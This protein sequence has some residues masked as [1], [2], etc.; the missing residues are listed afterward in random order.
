LELTIRL[1]P[2]RLRQWHRRLVERAA[3]LG[4]MQVTVAW[5]TAREAAPAGLEALY[6]FER[7]VHGR[8]ASDLAVVARPDD[9]APFQ[10]C[11][12]RTPDLVIDLCADRRVAGEPTWHVTFDGRH[13]EAAA[14]GALARGRTPVVSVIDAE[15]GTE[16]ASGHPGTEDSRVLVRA[17]ADVMARTITILVAALEGNPVF[18]DRH[19][20][21]RPLRTADVVRA[22]GR[23]MAHAVA[24]RLYR[25]LY[26]TPHWRTGWRFVDGPDV[27]VLGTHP[28]GGW[29]SLAD[30]GLRCYADPFPVVKDDR[31]YVF[32]E[33]MNPQR[34]R[35]VI[36]VVEFDEAGPIGAPRPV[37]DTGLHV[38]YPFV[39]EHAGAMWMVPESSA[40]ANVCLWR[41]R[42]FPDVWD[43]EAVLLSGIIAS[44]ATLFQHDGRWWMLATV[45]EEG[46]S[47]SD[48][49]HIW[50]ADALVGPWR[51]HRHNPVLVDLASA[52]PAGRVV[53]RDGKLL[54]PVQDCR[55]GYGAALAIAE[56]VRLDEEC[57]E[58][59]VQAIL[60]PG[61]SWPGH[62]LHMLNQAGRLECIDGA[63]RSTR[64]HWRRIVAAR[65]TVRMSAP[66]S[67]GE[68]LDVGLAKENAPNIDSGALFPRNRTDPTSGAR[69][70]DSLDVPRTWLGGLPI[71]RLSR[72]ET[73]DLM[74]EAV[75]SRSSRQR[76]LILTSAN[77]EV[78]SRC[79]RD[80]ALAAM[81]AV[82]DLISADG[83]PLVLAS[84]LIGDAP[85]PERVATTD[86]FH[87]VARRA[88]RHGISFYLFGSTEAENANACS[89]ILASYP[90]LKIAGRSH[91]YLTGDALVERVA[92][93]NALAPD[94]VWVGLG[95][96]REQ[97]F[98]LSFAKS[99]SNVGILKTSG[100]L[101]NFLSGT[102]AR[103]PAWMQGIGLEWA[104]RAA[105]EPRLIWRYAVTNPH[106]LYLLAR[107]HRLRLNPPHGAPN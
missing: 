11:Q 58:Q 37:L 59:R 31:T 54:R 28:P 35:G 68:N 40:E 66:G 43:K 21:G 73:A 97:A 32:V 44:D 39:F 90:N 14:V 47:Y 1:D 56:I 64:L 2:T 83:Q 99:L 94:I 82:A 98:C 38:S 60:G 49:L 106:A 86:L 71:T 3:R 70:A 29:Q 26:Q 36:S 46:G 67:L 93:I 25:R 84:K 24:R 52:R 91:G 20:V 81:F 41:A 74:V 88:Q 103:A 30:D 100:G 23:S 92:E 45:Q 6:A 96:P 42:R 95:V 107:S 62:K 63:T 48:S 85:L 101:F 7:L 19:P 77:G 16:L 79:Q 80:P 8:P 104:F 17:F 5:G 55:N 12:R 51:P 50:S 18:V 22:A 65:R 76:P 69:Q 4:E 53:R 78:I 105:T 61:P 72:Q 9:F 89:R 34:G 15:T 27:F 10:R 13:G 33:E 57:F 102:R 75:Q 87:D